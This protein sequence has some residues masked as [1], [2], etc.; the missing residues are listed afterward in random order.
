MISVKTG[1]KAWGNG[2]PD[3]NPRGDNAANVDA[4]EWEKA[5]G[6][7]N[8]GEILNKVAN[9]NWVDP[10]KKMRVVGNNQLDKDAFMKMMLAQLKNQDPTNPLK[11]HEMAAQLAQFTS[12][13]K[14]QN[15]DDTLTALKDQQNP[16]TNF[17]ALNFIGRYVSGDSAKLVRG[18]HDKT[19]EFPFTLPADAAEATI[20]VKDADG[21][22]IRK[23]E[24]RNLKKG[25]NQ[26]TWNGETDNGGVARPGEYSFEI[27]AKGK[28]SRKLAVDTKFNGQIT[29]VN[30]TNRGPVLLIGNKSVRLSDVKKIVDGNLKNNDQKASDVTALDLSQK[31]MKNDNERVN[32][33]LTNGNLAK[34]KMNQGLKEKLN[35]EVK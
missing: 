14:L 29:G 12:V 20:S 10:E 5:Y 18:E 15:I 35:K 6:D 22:A 27:V 28:D 8:M 9:P 13:E 30:Y 34:V 24:L 4:K 23:F 17:Q 33:A 31:N 7:K 3:L 26:V 25:D 19:H 11:S 32:A 16:T 21:Q 1:V 2:V